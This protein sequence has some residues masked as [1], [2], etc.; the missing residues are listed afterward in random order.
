[1]SNKTIATV[2]EFKEFYNKNAQTLGL[3]IEWLFAIQAGWDKE[4][5][6]NLYKEYVKSTQI[7]LNPKDNA[8]ELKGRPLE[9]LARYFLTNGGIVNRITEITEPGKWQIDGQGPL[10]NNAILLCWGDELCRQFGFQLYMEA[11]NHKAPMTNEEFSLHY[12][13][14]E[15]HDCYIGVIFS[16]SGYKISRG[17]GIA[18]SIHRNYWRK[19]FHLLLAFHSLQSVIVDDKAPLKILQDALGY[20]VNNSYSNDSSVQKLYTKSFCHEAAYTEFRRLFNQQNK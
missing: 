18:E 12:R 14:M 3:D 11:K 1:M 17:Q 19:R 10:N 8:T 7:Q 16:T 15:E 20:A 4:E 2:E 9:N 6:E 13:R 5:Y